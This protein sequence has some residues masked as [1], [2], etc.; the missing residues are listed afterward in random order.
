MWRRSA[1]HTQTHRDWLINLDNFCLPPFSLW[2][3]PTK[4][5]SNVL[6]IHRSIFQGIY[7]LTFIS[8]FCAQSHYFLWL[9]LFSLI[10]S[11]TQ[12]VGL[13]NGSRCLHTGQWCE[14]EILENAE[15]KA[16]SLFLTLRCTG[17]LQRYLKH[18]SI[19]P[20]DRWFK[21]GAGFWCCSLM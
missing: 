19:I 17:E 5:D 15:K 18:F 2:K 6:L 4:T 8:C 1:L 21:G 7:L 20:T 12:T 13:R 11:F 16:K 3:V 14:R 10:L 9:S